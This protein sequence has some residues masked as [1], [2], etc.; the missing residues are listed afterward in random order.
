[1][2]FSEKTIVCEGVIPLEVLTKQCLKLV[3]LSDDE[4]LVNLADTIAQQEPFGVDRI[5]V[6]IHNIDTTAITNQIPEIDDIENILAFSLST[7][8]KVGMVVTSSSTIDLVELDSAFI[9]A[10]KTDRN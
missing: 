6:W 7:I 8:N 1:M 2:E 5:V 3:I 10:G 4:N 9:E